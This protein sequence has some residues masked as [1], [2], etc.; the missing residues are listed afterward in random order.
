MTVLPT[1]LPAFTM[2]SAFIGLLCPNEARYNSHLAAILHAVRIGAFVMLN[3]TKWSVSS[4]G[5]DVK[6]F[7]ISEILHS[8]VAPFRMT[9]YHR[10]KHST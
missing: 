4:R 9:D 7:S 6:S 1:Q 5:S 3:V 10:A 2:L 8:A